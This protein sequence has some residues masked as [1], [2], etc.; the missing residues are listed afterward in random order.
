[1]VRLVVVLHSVSVSA[2][3]IK[4]LPGT[5]DMPT[6]QAE[7]EIAR[8]LTLPALAQVLVLWILLQG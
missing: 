5:P 7:P 2:S 6:G 4:V 3:S 8:Q 1:M